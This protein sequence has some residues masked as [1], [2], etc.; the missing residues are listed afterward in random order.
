MDRKP[1]AIILDLDG[2]LLRSDKSISE[3]TQNTLQEC[4]KLVCILSDNE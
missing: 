3:R 4:K 2:T 1:K